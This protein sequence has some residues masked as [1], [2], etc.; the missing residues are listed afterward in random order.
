MSVRCRIL[1]W[2]IATCLQCVCLYAQ[3]PLQQADLSKPTHI[4]P[5][6]FSPNAFPIPDMLTGEVSPNMRIE[7]QGDYY[8]GFAKDKTEDI[9]FKIHIP[10][11]TDRANLSIWMPIME[12]YQNSIERQRVQHLQDTV[13]MSGREAGDVYISTDIQLLRHRQWIP[14]IAIRAAMKTASGGGYSKARYYDCPG[15]FFDATIGEVFPFRQSDFLRELRLAGSIGF[16]CWQTDN[17]RQNDAVMYGVM[18]QWK[19]KYFSVSEVFSGYTGWENERN[20]HPDAHDAPM[21]LKTS[22]SG[23]YKNLECGL[24]YQYGLRDYP[25][26]QF[27]LSV[28]YNIDILSLVRNRGIH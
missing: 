22:V 12:F 23:Y 4:S 18:L 5:Y 20:N 10:L 26:H 11:F 8:Y 16:L 15:Y 17:G 27:R 6:Y 21:S 24:T 7:L 25:F 1:F 3:T 28:A 9:A 19:T 13:R 14:D 2:L